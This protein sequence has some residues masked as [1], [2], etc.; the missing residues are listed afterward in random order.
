[1]NRLSPGILNAKLNITVV[2]TEPPIN[3]EEPAVDAPYV[4]KL[5]YAIVPSSA[6]ITVAI[7]IVALLV[8][9]LLK[10]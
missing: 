4:T 2:G 9:A 6:T 5:S 3:C 7:I 8:N 1:M 10:S